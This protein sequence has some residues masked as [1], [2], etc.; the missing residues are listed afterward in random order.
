[1]KAIMLDRKL[2]DNNKQVH[3]DLQGLFERFFAANEHCTFLQK[4]RE[5]THIYEIFA[6]DISVGRYGATVYVKESGKGEYVIDAKGGSYEIQKYHVEVSW[7]SYGSVTY[8]HL[9]QFETAIGLARTLAFQLNEYFESMALC[10]LCRTAEALAKDEAE[11]RLRELKA[12]VVRSI[13]DGMQGAHPLKVR[14]FPNP[15]RLTQNFYYSLLGKRDV[16]E[17]LVMPRNNRDEIA[18]VKLKNPKIEEPGGVVSLGIT[19]AEA[20][21]PVRKTSTGSRRKPHVS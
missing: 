6:T 9:Q 18:V 5:W 4:G 15:H 13:G 17:V 7:Y 10:T 14:Y 3:D 2:N 19:S 20:R 16:Y 12:N 21:L 11:Q 1:M 8:E